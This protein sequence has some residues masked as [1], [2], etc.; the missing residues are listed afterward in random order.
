[1]SEMTLTPVTVARWAAVAALSLGT[2]A[3]VTS[4]M[5]PVGLLTAMGADLGASDGVMGLVMTACGLVGAVAAPLVAAGRT[6][7]R[8]VLTASMGL[9]AVATLLAAATPNVA[10]LLVA[11]LAAGLA[12][13]GF[14]ALAAGMAL[15]LVPAPAVPRATAIIMSG[16]A[17]A[18]VVGVPAGTLLGDATGWRTAVAA[19]G[20]LC[21]V[22]LVALLVV[23]PPLPATHTMRAADVPRLLT[24]RP[25]V[26]ACTLGLALVVVAHFAAYT[27]VRP[28]L[29][30]V[31]G[32]DEDLVG[33]LLLVYGLA[34][35]AG[36]FAVGALVSRLP[37]GSTALALAF[38]GGAVVLIPL[39]GEGT[40]RATLLLV[41]WGIGYGAV[42]VVFQTWMLRA[43]PDA[44][45]AG[46]ALI[47]TTFQIS[48]ALGSLLG[49]RLVDGVS[50]TSV[51][52]FAA[53]LVLAA[54]LTVHH[55][56]RR[57][58]T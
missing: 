39:V 6:D 44:P 43:V 7:R 13:G 20:V 57:V 34:G 48:I 35:V 47:V 1:M 46:S 16:I 32:V 3:L 25:A 53:V 10:V 40:G 14:W 41:A 15:R 22:V 28:V 56:T 30:D 51:M 17:L 9:L 55:A 12:F 8:V 58:R 2:F 5:L 26:R 38:L 21:L 45:E 27:F 33:T 23:L 19:V 31:S 54:L 52:W 49:G 29:E 18:S 4:E 11:R 36:N 24:R 42:P 37:Y 50:T